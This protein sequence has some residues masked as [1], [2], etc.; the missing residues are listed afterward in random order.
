MTFVL[1]QIVKQQAANDRL[2]RY[3]RLHQATPTNSSNNNNNN[4]FRLSSMSLNRHNAVPSS[5]L[6]CAS[7]NVKMRPHNRSVVF[8]TT[9]ET[10]C[11][12]PKGLAL[13]LVEQATTVVNGASKLRSSS[14]RAIMERYKTCRISQTYGK[15][16]VLFD[17][18][19]LA[20]AGLATSTPSLYLRCRI[21]RPIREEEGR[22]RRR[23]IGDTAGIDAA[24]A[25]EPKSKKFCLWANTASEDD[26][27]VEAEAGLVVHLEPALGVEDMEVEPILEENSTVDATRRPIKRRRSDAGLA[28][29]LKSNKRFCRR[30]ETASQVHRHGIKR[31][32]IGSAL[33]HKSKRSCIR[34]GAS[35]VQSV[36]VSRFIDCSLFLCCVNFLH[37]NLIYLIV[38]SISYHRVSQTLSTAEAEPVAE[39][40]SFE[41]ADDPI[42][43]DV[44]I[45]EEAPTEILREE[46]EATPQAALRREVASLKSSLGPYWVPRR[47][48][49][50]RKQPDRFV[51]SF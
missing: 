1:K 26:S 32:W 3:L 45:A 50:V 13:P 40:I 29:E 44:I 18:P 27:T 21:L 31:K 42:V 14:R 5:I 6:R 23:S 16:H 43:E 41:V 22:K 35:Q 38:R 7:Q 24:L 33:E 34:T 48:S 36:E 12:F 20:E 17:P 19:V 2:R 10:T 30:A 25:I 46:V 4:H 9:S 51:P 28:L 47:S 15:R 49:R 37:P 8:S 11:L 39:D